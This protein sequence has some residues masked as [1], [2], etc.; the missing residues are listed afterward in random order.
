MK[1][2]T[3]KI[4]TKLKNLQGYARRLLWNCL[5]SRRL[6]QV[7]M[8]LDI[9]SIKMSFQ[10]IKLFA[11]ILFLCIRTFPSSVY[12]AHPINA[13][14]QS[15]HVQKYMKNSSMYTKT[16]FVYAKTSFVYTDSPFV[17]M[18]IPTCTHITSPCTQ[19]PPLY[20]HHFVHGNALFLYKD[21]AFVYKDNSLVYTDNFSVLTNTSLCT[22]PLSS[23]T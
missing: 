11:S 4:R 3:R 15:F 16:P 23:S 13:H 20:T 5:Y 8:V 10:N 1:G 9:T 7:F 12:K 19:I 22:H 17:Y 6:L 14:E 21:T 18:L 2:S